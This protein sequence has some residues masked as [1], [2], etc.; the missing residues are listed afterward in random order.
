MNILNRQISM[1]STG[2]PS[3]M[4]SSVYSR[5]DFMTPFIPHDADPQ[6]MSLKDSFLQSHELLSCACG[7]ELQTAMIGDDADVD[8]VARD[9]NR[10]SVVGILDFPESLMFSGE[11]AAVE[12]DDVHFSVEM[13]DGMEQAEGGLLVDTENAAA[14]WITVSGMELPSDNG[15]RPVVSSRVVF[16]PGKDRLNVGRMICLLKQQLNL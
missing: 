16:T 6:F 13:T 1:I 12:S 3:S 10:I 7:L 4:G 15:S 5:L 11:V 2:D 9:E 8:L 14:F